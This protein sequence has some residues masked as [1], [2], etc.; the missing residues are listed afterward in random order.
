[1]LVC[2]PVRYPLSETSQSSLE[3][4]IEL[5]TEENAVLAVLHVDLYQ[6][7]RNVTRNDLVTHIR[8]KVDVPPRTRYVIKKGFVVEE[9]ILQT[10]RE[11]DADAVVVSGKQQGRFQ[12]LS[13][14]IF[15]GN[16][17]IADYLEDNYDCDC[18]I[19]E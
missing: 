17:G 14:L 6:K 12:R 13:E 19:M 16:V 2:V 15:P 18:V 9:V 4:G 7:E 3:R 1:M 5:A 11:L 10:V 8:S